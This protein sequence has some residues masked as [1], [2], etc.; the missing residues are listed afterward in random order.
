MPDR[1]LMKV[2]MLSTTFWYYIVPYT[3]KAQLFL[4][5]KNAAKR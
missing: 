4:Q 3:V 2:E 1:H 5:K